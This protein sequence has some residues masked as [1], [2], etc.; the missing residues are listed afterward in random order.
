MPQTGSLTIACGR[1]GGAVAVVAMRLAVVIVG[2]MV[3]VV[4]VMAVGH[5]APLRCLCEPPR[6]I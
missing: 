5:G 6:G 3:M 1:G 4:V 2:G